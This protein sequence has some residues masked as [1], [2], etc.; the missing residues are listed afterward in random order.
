MHRLVLIGVLLAVAPTGLA[1]A[2]SVGDP[3][4]LQWAEGDVAGMTGIYG[5]DGGAPIG[6]VE[7]HQTVQDGRLSS[8]RIARFRDGSSDEDRAEARIG[9][10]LEAVSGRSLIR[11]RDGEP[12]AD[13]RIDVAAGRI[14]ATWGRGDDRQTSSEQVAL[15]PGTYWGPLIFIAIRN[16]DANAADG[17]LIFKTVAPTP[18]PL[19]LDME[20][21]R[22]GDATLERTG[23]RFTAQ[24]YRLSPTVNRMLDPMIRMIAPRATFWILPGTPPALARFVGPRNYGRQE[25]VIE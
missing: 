15:P 25:I 19:V 20:I 11:D 22:G 23:I 10:T 21:S 2:R 7:Y 9:G 4:R 12:I 13:V 3:I 14:E 8:V 6:V 24:T 5:P 18:R 16:F 17:R 1:H